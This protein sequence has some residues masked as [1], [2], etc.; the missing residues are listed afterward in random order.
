MPKKYSYTIYDDLVNS[1]KNLDKT[2]KRQRSGIDSNYTFSFQFPDGD[3]LKLL[4][5]AGIIIYSFSENF[6]WYTRK[7]I[8]S[9]DFDALKSDRV[10]E[11]YIS[12]CNNWNKI[13]CDD[14]KQV[15]SKPIP[16]I[17]FHYWLKIHVDPR[18]HN[19]YIYVWNY[20]K[21]KYGRSDTDKQEILMK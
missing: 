14:V 8:D 21:Q 16:D 3:S 4:R 11:E 6:S 17:F 18:W 1:I 9:M 5:I 20:L 10:K 15:F 7:A 13:D 12:A 19:D 2:E